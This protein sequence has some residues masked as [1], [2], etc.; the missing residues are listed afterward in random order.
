M[1]RR[2]ALLLVGLSLVLVAGFAAWGH[3][4]EPLSG[5]LTRIGWYAE[6]DYGWTEPKLRF[7]PPPAEEGRLDGE[8]DALA[9]GDSFTASHTT[10]VAW[11][12]FF[13]HDTGLRTAIF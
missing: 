1:H 12:N 10:G 9:V 11:P 7:E 8:Y 4:L 3:W 2:Y 6:N 5:D 13:A